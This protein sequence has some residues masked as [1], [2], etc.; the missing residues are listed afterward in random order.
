[1]TNKFRNKGKSKGES[2]A[3]V[4]KALRL[5]NRLY[6]KKMPLPSGLEISPHPNQLVPESVFAVL[7]VVAVRLLEAVELEA[8]RPRVPKRRQIRLVDALYIKTI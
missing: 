7:P 6:T 2:K 8:R 5:K 1:M 3:L 4:L